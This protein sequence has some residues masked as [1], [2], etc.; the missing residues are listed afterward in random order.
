MGASSRRFDD[1]RE[2]KAKAECRSYLWSCDAQ[3]YLYRR[4]EL[5]EAARLQWLCVG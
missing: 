4:E 3:M 1:V 5:R 2:L